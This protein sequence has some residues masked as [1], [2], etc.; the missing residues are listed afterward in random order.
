[1]TRRMRSL[2]KSSSGNF[3]PFR[4]NTHWY[5][6]CVEARQLRS[7]EN[8]RQCYNK[9]SCIKRGAVMDKKIV[10]LLFSVLGLAAIFFVQTHTA[11]SQPSGIATDP[12]IR[13]GDPGAGDPFSDLT[14]TQLA[15]FTEGKT[16]FQAE[17]EVPDGLGP[18]LNLDSCAGC[19]SQPAIG[20][21]APAVNPQ[22]AFATKNGASNAVPSFITF[23][24]PVREARYVKNPDGS[25]DGG[26]HALFTITGRAD[27]Q[28]CTTA[29]PDFETAQA[30]NNV[31]F[32]IPTP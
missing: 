6:N 28:G 26:V 7:L 25:P 8:E 2:N 14:Q 21:S 22:V 10:A 1:M 16:D 19:H 20:G 23:D 5:H 13:G 30:Q 15:F 18:T 24:G 29:Q 4:I 3:S 27:A 32:R 12:G 9:F 17:E 31:I 11:S